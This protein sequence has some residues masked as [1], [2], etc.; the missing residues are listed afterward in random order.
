[1][2]GVVK[3]LGRITMQSNQIGWVRH[4]R[5]CFRPPIA[6]PDRALANLAPLRLD[7][8]ATIDGHQSL[9]APQPASVLV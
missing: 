5:L 9:S 4:Q 7:T 8:Q 2:A 6:A 1:M 3:L